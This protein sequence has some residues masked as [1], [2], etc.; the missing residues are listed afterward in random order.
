[1]K[2]FKQSILWKRSYFWLTLLF[3]L[4]SLS[5]HWLFGWY[6]FVDEETAHNQPVEMQGYLNQMLRDT[7]ENWQSE[8]LQLM[9][10]VAGL[11]LLLYV[12]SPTSKEGDDRKEAKID[13]IIRQMNPEH[14]QEL[15]KEWDRKYPKR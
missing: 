4:I 5:L 10:Q 2:N 11:A 8:F 7:F 15:Q 6:A 12:G 9:W 1:M 14:Y 3:F 13:Y